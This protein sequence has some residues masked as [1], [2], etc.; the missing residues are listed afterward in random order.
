ME[1][2]EGPVEP[3]CTHRWR[4]ESPSGAFS[5][6]ICSKCGAER[7]FRNSETEHPYRLQRAKRP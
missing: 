6:A 2:L 3:L 1:G 7:D 4:I 5:H